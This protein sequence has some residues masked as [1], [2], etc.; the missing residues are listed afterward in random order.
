MKNSVSEKQ[1]ALSTP[2]VAITNKSCL[3]LSYGTFSD[4]FLT[5]VTL[6]MSVPDPQAALLVYKETQAPPIQRS[7]LVQH[8]T[9]KT[10]P[11][12]CIRT[13]RGEEQ[14]GPSSGS[15][16]AVHLTTLTFH[17]P[18]QCAWATPN[19]RRAWRGN[20]CISSSKAVPN[21][22]RYS[23]LKAVVKDLESTFIT[24]STVVLRFL[25][26]HTGPYKPIRITT[27]AI[28]LSLAQIMLSSSA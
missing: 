17:R 28:S 10:A 3:C 11:C 26:Q 4:L 14:R 8:T 27:E 15:R 7:H 22:W 23:S 19:C 20:N 2:F 6:N 13:G 25:R 12:I 24:R 1:R 21:L 9:V 18:G 5:H 16:E